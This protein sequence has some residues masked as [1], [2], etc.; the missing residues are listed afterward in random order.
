MAGIW[1]FLILCFGPVSM[2]MTLK[3]MDKRHRDFM[4]TCVS[5]MFDSGFSVT[6]NGEYNE[7]YGGT[8]DGLTRKLE[9]ISS[10]EPFFEMFLHEYCHFLQWK[11]SPSGWVKTAMVIGDFFGRLEQSK[12]WTPMGAKKARES[13]GKVLEMEIDCET[14]VLDLI[15]TNKLDISIINYKKS[16]NV[17]FWMHG[18]MLIKERWMRK[19][20]HNDPVLLSCVDSV[21]RTP[22][23]YLTL[24]G[25]PENSRKLFLG[26]F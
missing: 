17:Y 12:A 25:F 10:V 26:Y 14:R 24:E 9:I 1:S 21:F 11:D 7:K 19:P 13:A 8:F 16:S 2:G 18:C 15:K 20:I 22:E 4:L 6:F 23:Q 3:N 5:D